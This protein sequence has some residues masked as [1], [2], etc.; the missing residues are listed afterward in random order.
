M[1]AVCAKGKVGAEKAAELDVFIC[2]AV[3]ALN[4]SDKT[5][6]NKQGVLLIVIFFSLKKLICSHPPPG[7]WGMRAD[8]LLLL[9]LLFQRLAQTMVREEFE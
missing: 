1:E 5:I 3:F 4:A 6:T 9:V 8:E 2:A 7:R